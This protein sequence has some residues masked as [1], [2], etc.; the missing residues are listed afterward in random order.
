MRRR[1]ACTA[2]ASTASQLPEAKLQLQTICTQ[3]TI[4][5]DWPTPD[6]HQHPQL[7]LVPVVLSV[8]TNLAF[9]CASVP[10]PSSPFSHSIGTFTSFFFA[11]SIASAYPAST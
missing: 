6:Q 5:C 3:A 2:E 1:D 11:N 9:L 8:P 7:R 10:N 4:A